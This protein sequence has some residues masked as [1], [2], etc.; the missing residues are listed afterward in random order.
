MPYAGMIC[1]AIVCA[2][3]GVIVYFA[4]SGGEDIVTMNNCDGRGGV[5]VVKNDTDTHATVTCANGDRFT[6]VT[7]W[8][9]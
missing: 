4:S 8:V 3:L 9:P 5:G 7:R 2:G 6:I 1:W